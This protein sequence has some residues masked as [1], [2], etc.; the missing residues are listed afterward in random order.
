[1]QVAI[2]N[3]NFEADLRLLTDLAEK[4]GVK[5]K[6]LNEEEQEDLALINAIN[7]GISNEFVDTDEFLKSFRN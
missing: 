2:L 5:V 4:I 6:Y 3:S 7:I 1:M